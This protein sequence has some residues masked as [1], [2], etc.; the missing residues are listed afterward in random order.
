MSVLGSISGIQLTA[1]SQSVSSIT[2]E[3]DYV[4]SKV[5]FR[6]IQLMTIPGLYVSLY[7]VKLVFMTEPW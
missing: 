1:A 2:L 3:T 5:P 4:I 7:S 6:S